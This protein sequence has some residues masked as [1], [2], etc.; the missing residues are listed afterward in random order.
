ME[1][2][3]CDFCRI[4]FQSFGS[5]LCK[6]CF[7]AL[8]EDFI[9]IREYLYD[10]EAGIEEVSEA[11]GVPTKTIMYLLK[12]ERLIV[13]DDSGRASGLLKCEVCKRSISTGK[14]CE[15]C[16]NEIVTTLN[17]SIN[18]VSLPRRQSNDLESEPR[19]GIA[20]LSLKD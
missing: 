1:F 4:P 5:K 17:E 14:M 2:I 9:K 15:R 13:K 7:A 19:K 8:D 18:F 16:K 12:E 11:T 20:K 6:D 10:N 3:K